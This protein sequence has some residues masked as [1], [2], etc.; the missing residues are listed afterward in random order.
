MAM[1]YIFIYLLFSFMYV[2]ALRKKT[3]LQLTLAE[4]FDTKTKIV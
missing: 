2:H 1:G 3:V 4:I